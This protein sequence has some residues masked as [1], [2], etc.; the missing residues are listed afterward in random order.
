MSGFDGPLHGRRRSNGNAA[1]QHLTYALYARVVQSHA[2]GRIRDRVRDTGAMQAV[3]G[4]PPALI[5][6]GVIPCGVDHPDGSSR[7]L[8]PGDAPGMG[9]WP[10]QG[11]LPAGDLLFQGHGHRAVVGSHLPAAGPDEIAA[12]MRPAK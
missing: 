2:L 8:H 4:P 3:T 6:L 1:T 10:R 5:R 12:R 11:W 9:E 7:S